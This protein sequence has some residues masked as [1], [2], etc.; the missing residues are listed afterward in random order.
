MPMARAEALVAAMAASLLKRG[1]LAMRSSKNAA[2]M[3]TGMEK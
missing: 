1:W 3:T 2:R